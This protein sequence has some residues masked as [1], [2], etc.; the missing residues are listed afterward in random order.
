MNPFIFSGVLLSSTPVQTFPSKRDPS[1]MFRRWCVVVRS[2]SGFIVVVSD[3]DPPASLPDWPA[4]AK[5]SVAF[6]E[7]QRCKDVPGGFQVRGKVSYVG[8]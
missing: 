5:V 3:W 7:C 1:R 2:D 8:K 4:G 6:G